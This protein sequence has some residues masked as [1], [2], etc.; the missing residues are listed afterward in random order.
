MFTN[1]FICLGLLAVAGLFIWLA[2]RALRLRNPFARW[3]LAVVTTVL[4]LCAAELALRLL[5]LPRTPADFQF[6][7]PDGVTT[8]EAIYTIQ[9]EDGALIHVRN[10]GIVV[11]PGQ[12]WIVAE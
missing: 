3:S 10:V 6:V 8:V 2:R 1:I 9:A 5:D 4:C 7:R 11:P 12:P